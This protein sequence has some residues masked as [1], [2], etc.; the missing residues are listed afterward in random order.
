MSSPDSSG[1]LSTLL[2]LVVDHRGKTP[3]K[4]GGDFTDSGVP[5]VSAIHIKNG[6][7][8]WDERYRFVTQEMYERWMSVK[9]KKNDVLL[10]SEAPLGEVALVE[11]NNPIVLSQ[12]LF[13]LR[14]NTEYLDPNYLRYFLTSPQGQAMLHERA[15]GSTVIGIKQSELMEIEI[16]L[17]S[18][19]AQRSVGS[20]LSTIDEKIRVNQQIA[21]TLGQIAQTIFNSWFVDFDPVHAKMHGEQ[22]IGM[23]AE[24]AALFPDSF[25]DSELGPIPSG[26][27][28]GALGDIV[29]VIDCLH[30]KK[31]E[32]LDS[33]RPYLQLDTI[34]DSGV[35]ATEK[36]A[37]ISDSDYTK[38]ISRIEV[39]P[40][41]CVI[42][43]V[44]RVGAVSQIPVNFK[45]AIGRNITALRPNN[46]DISRTYLIELLLSRFMRKEIEYRTDSGTI[47]DALNVKNIPSLRAVLPG[48]ALMQT[49]E[50]VA[51][52]LRLQMNALHAQNVALAKV[53]DSLLP[54][55]ISGELEIPAELLEA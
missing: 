40:G 35:L 17:L 21:S 44:G 6:R 15:S 13:A 4:L 50:K 49:F 29:Q 48:D 26:W 55:L 45:A 12:R 2:T 3:K 54:R 33:G 7:I 32:L 41:D 25:E 36:A 47:L 37:M 42:T 31:P 18:L 1:K 24:T 16:P 5:V 46:V 14:C 30:S 27:K 19:P 34:T 22:P 38:W 51:G 39:S 52:P 11:D 9:L 23:D 28:L 10:T 8:N 43:N 53:R 20:M